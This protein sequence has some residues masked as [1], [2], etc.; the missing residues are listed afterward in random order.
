MQM[1][2]NKRGIIIVGHGS[3]KGE[4]NEALFNIVV[5]LKQRL[6]VDLIEPAFFS[7]VQPDLPTAIDRLVGMGC[8]S[9]LILPFFLFQGNHTSRD[10]PQILE[11]TKSKY[12][13]LEICLQ[14]S[15]GS[16]PRILDMLEERILLS[17]PQSTV[18]S[19]QQNTSVSAG[20]P[21]TYD[22]KKIEMQ[23][24][25]IIKRRLSGYS[26]P[27]EHLPIVS[28]VIH[29]TGDFDFARTLKF[30]K[31]S[32]SKGKEALKSKCLI[33]TDVLMVKAGITR[34][35]GNRVLCKISERGIR[36][37]A[38]KLNVTR[39]SLAMESLAPFMNDSLITIGNAPTALEKVIE[40][41]RVEKIR[42]ALVVGVPVGL[43]GA[44]EA[45]RKLEKL[46]IAYITNS[47][48]KG[49]SPVAAAIVNA[50]ILL[51]IRDSLIR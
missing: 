21:R 23:S 12:P 19:P 34:K 9:I 41:I 48:S 49:G 18:Y 43:V 42:P 32:V 39:A 45:K 24:M 40:L 31:D 51:V 13:E 29:A 20:Y 4:A 15:I 30:H 22:P 28:R 3:H 14:K 27:E 6:E 26:I 25:E 36:G 1:H 2:R 8:S 38:K 5:S 7:I 17:S 16:D 11:E 33:I 35:L 47:G 37:K 46:D 10:I 44:A 50:L